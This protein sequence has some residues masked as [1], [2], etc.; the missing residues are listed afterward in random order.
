MNAFSKTAIGG[1]VASALAL[2]AL[3]APASA[4][5]AL[6]LGSTAGWS[7]ALSTEYVIGPDPNELIHF[8]AGE[9]WSGT[10]ELNGDGE[11]KFYV[12]RSN[13]NG[14]NARWLDCETLGAAT[15][16]VEVHADGSFAVTCN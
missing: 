9:T 7:V 15:A 5:T 6:G 8:T 4:K 14:I 2:S 13:G 10:V 12:P 1:A 3:A 11:M 16:T